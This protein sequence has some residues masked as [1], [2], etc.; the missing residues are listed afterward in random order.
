MKYYPR[1]Y[2]SIQIWEE[3]NTSWVKKMNPSTSSPM[4][5]HIVNFVPSR[6]INYHI[7]RSQRCFISLNYLCCT[8][9]HH[10]LNQNPS[11]HCK[12]YNFTVL[13]PKNELKTS[14][15]SSLCLHSRD[16]YKTIYHQSKTKIR[17]IISNLDGKGNGPN[18][19]PL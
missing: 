7:I 3:G 9:P 10:I 4:L 1:E 17:P 13:A 15:L 5:I 11:L 18:S 8:G 16:H 6:L 12:D 14:W 19:F 2:T